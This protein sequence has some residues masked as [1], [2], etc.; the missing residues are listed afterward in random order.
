MMCSKNPDDD[1]M[2]PNL[3]SKKMI[4][5]QE[6]SLYGELTVEQARV[7]RADQARSAA[8]YADRVEQAQA[9]AECG[10]M[11]HWIREYRRSTLSCRLLGERIRMQS[12]Y[13]RAETAKRD[14][15]VVRLAPR[16]VAGVPVT[17]EA[18]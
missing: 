18:A 6:S 4:S 11:A 12:R 17:G 16:P 9:D 3:R 8:L 15:T 14:P 10:A 13:S 5:T 7:M 1:Q 2:Q